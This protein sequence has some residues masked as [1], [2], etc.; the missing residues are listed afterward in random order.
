MNIESQFNLVAKEYDINRRK[1][2]PCFEEFYVNTT[3][4]LAKTLTPK[5]VLDLGAGTG[6]LSMYWYENFPNAEFTLDDIAKDML[7]IAKKRFAGIENIKFITDNYCKALPE[8]AFD[9]IISALSIHHLEDNEKL[10]LFKTIYD[11][12]PVSGAFINYD[13][14]CFDDKNLSSA[15]DSIWINSLENSGLSENDLN[16]WK[17]RRKLD[18]ECSVQKEIHMLK[19][20]GFETPEC[21]Y[22]YK[23]FSVIAAVKQ[24]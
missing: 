9:L 14:F 17:E 15:A 8:G 24:S 7:E 22:L 13:Q 5:C 1:F 2:I 10:N 11:R 6:L 18:R 16:L 12:L 20:S 23:K 4:L 19:E 3:K 21:V